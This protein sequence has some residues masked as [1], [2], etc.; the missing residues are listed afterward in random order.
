MRD[1][2]KHIYS[3]CQDSALWRTM[4]ATVEQALSYAEEKGTS[5]APFVCGNEGWNGGLKKI[6]QHGFHFE[7]LHDVQK[8]ADVIS[9]DYAAQLG[10]RLSV[11]GPRDCS[12][13]EPHILAFDF[14]QDNELC[15]FVLS[16]DRDWHDT[17]LARAA[18]AYRRCCRWDFAPGE[19]G[20]WLCYYLI[21]DGMGGSEGN[22][23]YNGNV[24]GFAILYDRDKDGRHESLGHVWT[25]AAARRKG[26]ARALIAH[27]RQ[28]FPLQHVERPLTNDSRGLFETVWPEAISAR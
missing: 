15:R 25:A 10:P 8:L 5:E 28:H 3:N 23:H 17:G 20:I 11:E 4:L 6:K 1:I 13:E 22:W 16:A 7:L 2:Y 26:V 18:T 12:M 27:A 24:V 21:T 19:A 9:E 14:D